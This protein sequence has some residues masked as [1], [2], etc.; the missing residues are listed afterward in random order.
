MLEGSSAHGLIHREEGKLSTSSSRR[1]PRRSGK[2][3]RLPLQLPEIF[4][5]QHRNN[6]MSTATSRS[7]LPQRLRRSPIHRMPSRSRP[8]SPSMRRVKSSLYLKVLLVTPT[9]LPADDFDTAA[10]SR[11]PWSNLWCGT[12]GCPNDYA[13]GA[14]A[15]GLR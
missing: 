7:T 3:A 14:H 13:G 6:N 5:G 4:V 1:R 15:V 11:R 2:P 8:T 9:S 12:H 10:G